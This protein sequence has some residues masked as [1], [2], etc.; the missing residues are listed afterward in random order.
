MPKILVIEDNAENMELML[1]LLKSFGYRPVMAFDAA[2]A[3]ELALSIAPALILCDINLPGRSGLS[4]V[5]ELKSVPSLRHVPMVAVTAMTMEGD[6]ARLLNA[7]FDAYIGK[8]FEPETLRAQIAHFLG[9][10]PA[11]MEADTPPC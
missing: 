10:P 4:I 7:G 5:R 3:V 1:Y 2:T 8:P 11:S 9:T 6:A